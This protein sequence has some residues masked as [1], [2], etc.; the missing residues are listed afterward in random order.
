MAS[1]RCGNHL[2]LSCHRR[3]I[4]LF[5]SRKSSPRCS[6]GRSINLRSGTS[7]SQLY[8]NRRIGLPSQTISYFSGVSSI[9]NSNDTEDEQNSTSNVT[10]PATTYHSLSR[11]V[12][13]SSREW[14]II[15]LAASTLVVTSSVTLLL[16]YASGAVI[17]YTIASGGD[18]TASPLV[19]ASG[20]FG[21]SALAGGGVYLRTIWLAKA[22]NS[23]VARLKQQLYA[24]ILRQESS[25]L[26]QQTTGDLLSRL[27]SDAQLLQ[28][29]L[30]TQAVAGLR[31]TIMTIGAGGMLL[32]TSPVLALISCMTLPPVFILTRHFSRR[33][34]KRQE[35]V[36]KKLGE[37]TSL[38]E[39][40]LNHSATVKQSAAENFE[41]VRYRNGVA[42]AHATAVD[43]AHMQ[44]KLEASAHVAANGAILGVLGYG[45]SMV[46]ENSITPGD[47][48]G[49]VLYSLL[50]SGNLSSL[51]SIYS[52]MVRA[53]A[54]STR[55][56][57]VIDRPSKIV[58]SKSMDE[59]GRL[60][61]SNDDPLIKIE[62]LTV[63]NRRDDND[64]TT[65]GS[66]NLEIKNKKSPILGAASIKIENLSFRYPSRPDV[67]VIDDLN[68]TVP[69]GS[70]I[71]LV[72]ASGSGKSTI[73]NLLTR[74][75][76]ADTTDNAQ[77]EPSPILIN[78]RPICDYDTQDLRQMISVVSQ[79]P[80]LFRGTIRDNIRYGVWDR[81]SEDTITD[82]ARQ[83]YVMDFADNFPDGLDTLVGPRGT[84]LSGGQRQRI[85]IARMLANRNASIFILDE[86]TS[87]LDAQSEHYVQ[88]A[89]Q[90]IFKDHSGKT[91]ISI[92]HR[93]STIRHA[94]CIAV[95]HQGTIVQTGTFDDLSTKEGPFRELMKTQLVR[96]IGDNP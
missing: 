9:Q 13:M 32:Y 72:G 57:E 51:T 65:T 63:N 15:G 75:Y 55:V 64:K 1:H 83:A 62:Y 80:V 47:L 84:Q 68:L 81:A 86:A 49:F 29:A 4:P 22:S 28:G 50:M 37:A 88:S 12:Q 43:T 7:A 93:L 41:V 70:T 35:E 25:Y 96:D 78:G 54:A 24:S 76:D 66:T 60:L 82:A 44:A 45:G 69:S 56:L 40:A 2:F 19:L 61:S 14:P 17:D 91:I 94:T 39:Q 36:Q 6:I 59:Q 48:S 11:L 21:L 71:A 30:T 58:S 89:L 53:M 42:D 34:K 73:G 31:A 92:A 16:P 67:P 95:M 8:L 10:A 52:D 79:D 20:L 38:A 85:A 46:L 90:K 23:I 26:D 77:N 87:A 27:T 74:L 33:L 3:K 18:G 5:R